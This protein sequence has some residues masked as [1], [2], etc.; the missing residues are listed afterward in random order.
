M[1]EHFTRQARLLEEDGI[2]A[3]AA[4]DVAAWGAALGDDDRRRMAGLQVANAHWIVL[5]ESL[6]TELDPPVKTRFREITVPISVV[7][8]GHDFEG[9]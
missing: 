6:G 2:A 5:P 3:Y 1:Q 9:T 8:G 4:A 7:A